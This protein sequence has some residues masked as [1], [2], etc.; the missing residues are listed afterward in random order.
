[1]GICGAIRDHVYKGYVAQVTS[2]YRPG[3]VG[4]AR[5]MDAP[6]FGKKVE[7]TTFDNTFKLIGVR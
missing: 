3:I 4:I 7:R 5:E 1:M 2:R 6:T